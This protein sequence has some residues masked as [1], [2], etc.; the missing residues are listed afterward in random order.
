MV[1]FLKTNKQTNKTKENLPRF[2]AKPS[3]VFFP[4]DALRFSDGESCQ[5]ISI[6]HSVQGAL[7]LKI[8][9]G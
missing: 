8:F 9:Q 7:A 5:Q 3:F 1:V 2:Q 4:Q 6:F